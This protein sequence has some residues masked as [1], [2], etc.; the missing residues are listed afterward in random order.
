[1]KKIILSAA[2]FASTVYATPTAITNATICTGAAT[3]A[4]ATGQ[5][6]V[7]ENGKIISLGAQPA[8]NGARIID[9]TGKYLTPGLIDS[10]SGLGL[11]EI[12]AERNSADASSSDALIGAGV[13]TQWAVNP[14]A[15]NFAIARLGGVTRAVSLPES[16]KSLFGG[17]GT[18][19]HTAG[20]ASAIIRARA[21]MIAELGENGADI[22]GGSR[23]ASFVSFSNA[24][25]EAA[26]Y[27]ANKGRSTSGARDALTN[28]VDAEALVSIVQG[29][30][31]IIIKANRA[32]DIRNV[33]ALKKKFSTLKIIIAGA[34][35][36]WLVANEL[37]AAKVPVIVEAY[38]NLPNSF[39]RL[40][41]TMAN[42]ARLKKAGVRVALGSFETQ[43]FSRIMNQF[44][45]NLMAL[46]APDA[47]TQEQA[48]ALITSAPADIFGMED[49]GIL[50]PGKSA[51]IVMWD[52]PPLE[53]M[54]AP[55]TV[56]IA[57][58]EQKM[59]SRQTKLRDRYKTLT[60]DQPF[61]YRK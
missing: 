5:T 55:V 29:S 19:V 59:D 10:L 23:A 4:C 24:L 37:A 2:L 21:F 39:E 51:D 44:A 43:Q 16:G 61:Q 41:A 8:P 53:T 42:T 32:I 35:E 50:A 58:V 13:D 27:A 14:A 20:G 6:L 40:A 34:S 45:G 36:G 52:G 38:D 12:E 25:T 15:A 26:Q 7:I 46:P 28:R 49:V 54:S 18:I 57:G 33:I 9:G 17:F 56:I 1:M 60:G 30:V 47:L 3:S 22:A 31:P 11:I 48:L